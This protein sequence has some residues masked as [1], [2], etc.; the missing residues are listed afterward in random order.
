MN[1]SELIIVKAKLNMRNTED[2][3][4]EAGFKSGL[5]PNHVFEYYDDG[6]LRTYMGDVLFKGQELILPGDEKEVIV[7]F[8]DHQSI[9]KYIKVSRKW[10]LHEGEKCTGEAE[11]L[12]IELPTTRK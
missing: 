5:R 7:R 12:E 6:L 3:G 1:S 9:R 4:R 2:G 8:L 10:W 11:M